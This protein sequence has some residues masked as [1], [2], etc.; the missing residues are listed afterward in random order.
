M[1]TFTKVP[2]AIED[3]LQHRNFTTSRRQF[4][5]TSGALVVSFS[6]AGIVDAGALAAT[7]V[8][9]MQP[10]HRRWVPIRTLTSGN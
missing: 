9:K 10:G 4:L 3:I 2:N 7:S 6:A 5:K 1:T 8:A